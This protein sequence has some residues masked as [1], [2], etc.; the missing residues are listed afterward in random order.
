M[1]T[2]SRAVGRRRRGRE[3]ALRVLFEVEGTDKNAGWALQYQGEDLGAAPDVSAFAGEIVNGCLAHADAVD[4]AI[5]AASE[6]WA[7]VDLG[8]VE[9]ALLR[10]GTYELL[11]ERG[12]PIA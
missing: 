6:N 9:R 8:K 3:L 12:T 7:L 4:G 2:A 10:M 5:A 11:Y 1:T